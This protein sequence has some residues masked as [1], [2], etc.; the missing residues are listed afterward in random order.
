[1]QRPFCRT[2]GTLQ[3]KQRIPFA[4][5]CVRISFVASGLLL[6]QSQSVR[7]QVPAAGDVS[8]V[9]AETAEADS[10]PELSKAAAEVVENLLSSDFQRRQAAVGQL[11]KL[12][13]SDLLA[14]SRVVTEQ[15]DAEAVRRLIDILERLYQSEDSNAVASASSLL[16]GMAAGQRWISAE[17]AS[18]VLDRNWKV[19]IELALQELR[20]SGLKSKPAD[21]RELWPYVDQNARM[22][23]ANRGFPNINALSDSSTLRV[24]IDKTWKGSDRDLASLERLTPLASHGRTVTRGRV[25][26]FLIDGHPLTNEQETALKS[27]FGEASVVHRGPVCLGII[28]SPSFATNNGCTVSHVEPGSSADA[29]GIHPHDLITHVN[30]R[31]VS[32]FDGLVEL[33]REFDV[34][35]K[36]TMKV[37]RGAGSMNIPRDFPPEL[38]PRTRSEELTIDVTLKGWYEE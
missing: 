9:Q 14:V 16:E 6:W 31:E 34:N 38:L 35:D 5:C 4:V 2:S 20:Q 8:A 36:V 30:D 15:P 21:V 37:R 3:R 22:G 24:V 18:G 17:Q 33:L 26:V 10:A 7:A 11:Q 25:A 29:A 28:G 19:R 32:D 27:L 12:Q 23:A 13:P 1:M